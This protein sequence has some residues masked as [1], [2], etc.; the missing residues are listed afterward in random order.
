M[1]FSACRRAEVGLLGH[2]IG[3]V[4]GLVNNGVEMVSDHED[5]EHPNHTLDPECLMHWSYESSAV[6]SKVQAEVSAGVPAEEALGFCAPSLQD[7][8]AFR[9]Q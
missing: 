3:H 9:G 8:A 5:P 2:E 1:S 7:L 6:V 4:L